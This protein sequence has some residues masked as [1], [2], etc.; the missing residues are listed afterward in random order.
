M[1][2]PRPSLAQFQ[3][4]DYGHQRRPQFGDPG[5]PPQPQTFDYDH[6]RVGP[7]IRPGMHPMEVRDPTIPMA[8]YHDLPAG[9]IVPLV[10]V[11]YAYIVPLPE[12]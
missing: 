9:L 10:Q 11:L 1:F 8:P 12:R 4:F 2:Q 6:G 7:D 3:Q 5:A